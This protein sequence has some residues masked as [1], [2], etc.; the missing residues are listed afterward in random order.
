ALPASGFGLS[1]TLLP[2]Y[3]LKLIVTYVTIL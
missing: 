3:M 2:T 1:S